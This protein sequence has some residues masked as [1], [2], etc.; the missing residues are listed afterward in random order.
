M[1]I[2]WSPRAERELTQLRDYI[3]QDSP[4]YAAQFIERVVTAV[5]RLTAFPHMGR[6]APEA[7]HQDHIREIIIQGYRV[8]YRIANDSSVQ[9]V[10]IVHGARNSANLPQSWE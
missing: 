5:D 10:T 9:I 7:G 4:F 6:P 2:D 8:I 1:K 3:A